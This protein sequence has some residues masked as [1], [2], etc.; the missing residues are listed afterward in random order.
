MAVGVMSA[1][2]SEAVIVDTHC[3][4]NRPRQLH[5]LV[6]CRERGEVVGRLTEARR[7]GAAGA[8][9]VREAL[10]AQRA[11]KAVWFQQVPAPRLMAQVKLGLET[12]GDVTWQAVCGRA[13]VLQACMDCES[14]PSRLQPAST[15]SN[16]APWTPHCI[17][18]HAGCTTASA[19]SQHQLPCMQAATAHW[20]LPSHQ[21]DMAAAP[22]PVEAGSCNAAL[23]LSVT[24][25]AHLNGGDAGLK[26]LFA[27]LHA[28]LAPGGLLV[29]EPQPWRSYKQALRKQVLLVSCCWWCGGQQRRGPQQRLRA[30]R[31]SMQGLAAEQ[32]RL[33]VCWLRT[34]SQ[35]H[36]A[37]TLTQELAGTLHAGTL[38]ALQLRPD[39]FV[40]HLQQEGGF[41]L[42]R[43][44]WH[45]MVVWLPLSYVSACVGTSHCLPEPCRTTSAV[46][47][48]ASRYAM[49]SGDCTTRPTLPDKAEPPRTRVAR[50]A[51]HVAA[52]LSNNIKYSG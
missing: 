45:R 36:A 15:C 11:L 19:P 20:A 3:I 29:L 22:M 35:Q 21:G 26:A 23:C 47:I 40:D 8:A 52:A 44:G 37:A 28:A 10:T 43:R 12:F 25:W 9:A 2:W 18:Q 7:Q 13:L 6:F 38:A 33:L 49:H 24:K 4:G 31:I 16:V 46:G 50:E 5:C 39:A 17:W 42:V 30:A 51:M 1:C 14:A 32:G 34:R 41:R 48:G 27:A